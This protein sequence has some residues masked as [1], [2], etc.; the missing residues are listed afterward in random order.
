MPSKKT[1]RWNEFSHDMVDHIEDYV[2]PQYGDDGEDL[3]AEWQIK[4][5]ISQI[6]KYTRRSG[7]NKR[8]GQAA[9]DLLKIA[10]HAQMAYTKMTSK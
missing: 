1:E 7:N 4:D 6:E 8:E 2:I 5:H 3:Y 9:L 10:H